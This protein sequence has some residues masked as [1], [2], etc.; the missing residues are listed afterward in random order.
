MCVV[1]SLYLDNFVRMLVIFIFF[2]FFL[3]FDFEFKEG[4]F[5]FFY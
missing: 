5:V 1:Y 3:S 2:Y 4:G